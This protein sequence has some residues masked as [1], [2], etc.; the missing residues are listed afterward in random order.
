MGQGT[1]AGSW[2]EAMFQA[3][4][5]KASRLLEELQRSLLRGY[6]PA[7]AAAPSPVPC[8]YR[9]LERVVLTDEVGRTLF[10]EY[11]NHR[12]SARGEEETGWVLLGLRLTSEAVV[13]ATLP[14]GAERNAGVSH[15]RFNASAQALASRIV[16]QTD[17]RLTMLGVVH[18]HPGSLRHPSDGDFQG[19]SQWVEHLRGREGVFGIG[20]AD[21]KPSPGPAIAHQPQRHMQ[22]LGELCFSWYALTQG[23]RQYRPLPLALTLGPDLARPLHP[24]W[25]TI[26]RHAEP[27]DR[28]C[29]Q[30]AGVT[31]QTLAGLYGPALAVNIVLA[32]AGE[33]LRLILEDKEVRYYLVRG[34]E[35][36]RVEVHE[37]QVD[38]GVYLVLA[39]LAAAG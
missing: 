35:L 30:Q 28:L 15:V 6:W 1:G 7:P 34:D 3:L 8:Q 14:A 20:T 25:R 13:L 21:A 10:E 38:R 29:R 9:R 19:D 17:R 12:E 5:S 4:V 32:G 26:E 22:C 18:S 24:L 37:P 36:L 39:E 23:D 33:R 27:L 16:R 11:N 31:F 2:I